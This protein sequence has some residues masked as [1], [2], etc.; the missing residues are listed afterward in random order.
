MA[1]D[2][3]ISGGTIV[4]GTGK[5]RYAGDIGISGGKIVA[6]GNAAAEARET[7]DATGRIVAPGFVDIH[8]H[9]DAQI[10]WDRLLSISPWHGVT[11]VVMGNC[12]FGVAPTH[13]AHRSLITRTLEKVEGMSVAALEAGMGSDW[14]FESFPGYLDAIERHGSGINVAVL[15]GHTP[16]RLYVMGEEATEREASAE[17]VARMRALVRDGLEAG[18]LGDAK[19]GVLQATIGPGLMFDEFAALSRATGA[20]V[21]WTAL[22]AGRRREGI[23]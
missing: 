2:L 15:I 23:D 9:Y 8:T 20:N 4:D 6:L 7:I 10:L 21:S 11:T 17:E 19:R 12:G 1:F 3:K 13:A 18:A 14:G 5:P 22:L 16:V